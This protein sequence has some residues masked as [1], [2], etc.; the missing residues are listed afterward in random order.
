LQRTEIENNDRIYT[1]TD[2]DGVKL[3]ITGH[4]P[5]EAGQNTWFVMSVGESGEA[6]AGDYEDAVEL[7]TQLLQRAGYRVEV[8]EDVSA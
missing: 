2:P 5:D 1:V 3:A 6:F 8:D 7:A 4:Q